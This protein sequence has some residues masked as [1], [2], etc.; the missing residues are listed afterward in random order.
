MVS[1]FAKYEKGLYNL[2]LLPVSNIPFEKMNWNW[3][4]NWK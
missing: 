4:L 1:V 3:I 2:L